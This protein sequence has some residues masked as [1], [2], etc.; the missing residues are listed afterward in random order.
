MTHTYLLIIILLLS[1]PIT[2]FLEVIDNQKPWQWENLASEQAFCSLCS[3]DEWITNRLLGDY[4]ETPNQ[5]IQE[6]KKAAP[7]PPLGGLRPSHPSGPKWAPHSNSQ[8]RGSEGEIG[9]PSGRPSEIDVLSSI[10]AEYR[11]QLGTWRNTPSQEAL[12][13]L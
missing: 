1:D 12:R 7:P 4:R 13:Y 10:G 5:P 11:G 2:Q 3:A 9:N 6:G 8:R